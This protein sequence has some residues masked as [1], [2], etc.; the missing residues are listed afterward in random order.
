MD[1]KA[2]SSRSQCRRIAWIQ[3]FRKT[4]SVTAVPPLAGQALQTVNRGVKWTLRQELRRRYDAD[5]EGRIYLERLGIDHDERFFYHGS[6][7]LPTQLALRRLRLEPEDVIVDVGAGKG[8]AVLLA[9]GFPVRRVSGVEL[10]EEL[11]DIARA[12]IERNA[13]RIR[14][15][16]VE[17][18]A[19]DALEWDMPD[20]VTVVYLFCPFVGRL[21][22]EFMTRTLDA[23]DRHPRPLR[24]VYNLPWE[25]NWLVSTGRVRV[26]DVVPSVWP[27]RPGW[28][29]RPYVIVTYGVGDRVFP[30]AR[31]LPPSRAA[32][33]R[34]TGP[35]DTRFFLKR[36]GHAVA[37]SDVDPRPNGP[38][39]APEG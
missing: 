28:S 14:A 16:D 29:T 36:P 34:W 24:L 1:Q 31:G 12:N 19:V 6:N 9:A 13:R 5:V 22:R 23:C 35:N 4:G 10:S 20:D 17:M 37:S 30:R 26:L 8:L 32:R 15:R 27:W 21:F 33:A 38:A 18:V 39:S 2:A 11:V 25:H 7:W 3:R